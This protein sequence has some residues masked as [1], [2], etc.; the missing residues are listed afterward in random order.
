MNIYFKCQ[1]CKHENRLRTDSHTRV[2]FAIEN[3]N[4]LELKCDSCIW[5]NNIT[6]NKL[7]AKESKNIAIVA[8]FIFLIG[9][10]FGLYFLMKMISEMKTGMGIFAVAC[11]LLIPSWIYVTLN[12]E[13]V[14]RV[15]TFNQTYVSE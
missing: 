4:T 12:K 5:I 1:A 3:G 10:A 2:E 6:V 7:Y 14:R 9:S 15:K 13:E 8:G 11:G